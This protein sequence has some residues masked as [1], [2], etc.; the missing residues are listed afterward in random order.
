MKKIN[1]IYIDKKGEYAYSFVEK[2]GD[3]YALRKRQIDI[4]RV[5]NFE[6]F[7]NT[8]DISYLTH[9]KTTGFIAPDDAKMEDCV[10]AMKIYKY[11][12]KKFTKEKKVSELL[13]CFGNK[14]SSN[15]IGEY[16]FMFE[17]TV[18]NKKRFEF[19]KKWTAIKY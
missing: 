6:Y 17:E 7:K 19:L 1:N 12:Y 11:L 5:G 10:K 3:Q 2:G 14:L 8:Q 15:I 9:I 16:A 4:Y 18:E 13:E